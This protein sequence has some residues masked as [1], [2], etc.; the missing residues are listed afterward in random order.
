[1]GRF[2]ESEDFFQVRERQTKVGT[3][4]LNLFPYLWRTLIQDTNLAEIVKSVS[5]MAH[6]PNSWTHIIFCRLII[7]L[8]FSW[9]LKYYK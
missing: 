2:H 9:H 1:M 3:K 7:A 5:F 4:L 8:V 6:K